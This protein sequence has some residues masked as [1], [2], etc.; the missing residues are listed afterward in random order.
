M[1]SFESLAPCALVDEAVSRFKHQLSAGPFDVTID[2][3]QALPRV[4]A[5]RSALVLALDN[6]IDNA[7]RY[8][9]T[10]KALML[11]ARAVG[12]TVEFSVTDAGVGIPADD[13]ERVQRRFSRGRAGL[14]QGSGL[15]LAIVRRIVDD[16][17]GRLHIESTEGRGTTVR[18]IVPLAEE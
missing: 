12:S 6:V 4:R 5:D 2:V 18:L 11:V 17:G 14:G 8:S 1:Y 7:I 3:D 10:A 16:H 13:L 15:G 9:G